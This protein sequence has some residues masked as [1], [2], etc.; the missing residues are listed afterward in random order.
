MAPGPRWATSA[1]EFES[2]PL[3]ELRLSHGGAHRGLGFRLAESASPA[4]T[5]TVPGS[6]RFSP[7]HAAR[8]GR[9]PGTEQLGP[10]QPT[11]AP[12]LVDG[13]RRRT[14]TFSQDQ[15]LAA[16]ERCC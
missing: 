16:S 10:C 3:T 2:R 8:P 11:S 14:P 13:A 9:P 6:G 1:S 7:A 5:V 12:G 4:V 15:A